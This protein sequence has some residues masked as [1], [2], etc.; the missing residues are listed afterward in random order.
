MFAGRTQGEIRHLVV[1][2][3]RIFYEVIDSQNRINILTVRHAAR[4]EPFFNG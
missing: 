1:G 3:Y 4:R 2:N